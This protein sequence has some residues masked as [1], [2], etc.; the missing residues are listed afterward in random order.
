MAQDFTNFDSQIIRSINLTAAGKLGHTGRAYVVQNF[1]NGWLGTAKIVPYQHKNDTEIT[2]LQTIQHPFIVPFISVLEGRQDLIFLSELANCYNLFDLL[3]KCSLTENIAQYIAWQILLGLQEIHKAGYIH[4]NLKLDNILFRQSSNAEGIDVQLSN[5]SLGRKIGDRFIMK[6]NG[7]SCGGIYYA[8][9]AFSENTVADPKM[10]M[11]SFGLVLYGLLTKKT[12]RYI[13]ESNKDPWFD[14]D[15]E[16]S[17]DAFNLLQQ[18]L[19]FNPMNRIDVD[20]ALQSNFFPAEWR[21]QLRIDEQGQVIWN[22]ESHQYIPQE[23]F[24]VAFGEGNT[25]DAAIIQSQL[26][27]QQYAFI[28]QQG[29]ALPNQGISIEQ[30]YYPVQQSTQQIQ[31]PEIYMQQSGNIMSSS[32]QQLPDGSFYYSGNSIQQSGQ[33]APNFT[34]TFQGSG[35]ITG[36]ISIQG[37][38]LSQTQDSLSSLASST[39]I[40]RSPYD[41]SRSNSAEIGSQQSMNS[42]LFS[43]TGSVRSKRRVRPEDVIP[44][45]SPPIQNQ[46]P[47]ISTINPEGYCNHLPSQF[48]GIRANTMQ[49]P[50]AAPP[51]SGPKQTIDN[52]LD[53]VKLPRTTIDKIVTDCFQGNKPPSEM[54]MQIFIGFNKDKH[55]K[56]QIK[57]LD[58]FGVYLKRLSEYIPK[59]ETR[60]FRFNL[61]RRAE[62]KRLEQ[63]ELQNQRDETAKLSQQSTQVPSQPTV[64]VPS[65]PTVQV[66]SIAAEILSTAPENATTVAPSTTSTVSEIP[67]S[68][69][70][71]IKTEIQVT[72]STIPVINQDTPI[73]PITEAVSSLSVA[74]PISTAS[75]SEH[76]NSITAPIQPVNSLLLPPA[77]NQH[78]SSSTAP[79]HPVSATPSTSESIQQIPQQ[80]EFNN[81][82]IDDIDEDDQV[83]QDLLRMMTHEEYLRTGALCDVLSEIVKDRIIPANKALKEGL[84]TIMNKLIFRNPMSP[85]I[86]RSHMRVLRA[87][88]HYGEY[89]DISQLVKGDGTEM[90]RKDGIFELSLKMLK[91]LTREIENSSQGVVNPG[92]LV[93]GRNYI[94]GGN[95]LQSLK[96]QKHRGNTAVGPGSEEAKPGDKYNKEILDMILLCLYIISTKGSENGKDVSV[97]IRNKLSEISTAQTQS[98]SQVPPRPIGSDEQL[99]GCNPFYGRMVTCDIKS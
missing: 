82:F 4:G 88:S 92:N 58:I 44:K 3:T 14:V 99:K 83:D 12:L 23:L 62:I 39:Y 90:I 86:N 28:Y 81:L 10:D 31:Y 48:G 16:M 32:T 49:N 30:S 66:P 65:Q 11:F 72:Y 5:F 71:P 53:A 1:Q 75:T 22:P 78:P 33:N 97:K 37:Q 87:L 47:V 70:A 17:Q 93:K 69:S 15:E 94:T 55:S 18:L 29:P 38:N 6:E 21:D 2:M 35:N 36:Q 51:S 34:Q 20:Q 56:E 77:G 57:R 19:C 46:Q 80:T 27:Q 68:S 60:L 76:S 79:V 9:E 41:T 67:T 40:S 13:K 73:Q 8:P 42:G 24:D 96:L 25:I 50:Y 7:L 63:L 98:G 64:Q 59:L 74:I 26:Q 91:P 85:Q 84:M 52:D 95:K 54:Y 61:A 89:D 43:S 45:E